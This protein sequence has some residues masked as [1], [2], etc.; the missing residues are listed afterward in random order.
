MEEIINPNEIMQEKVPN[1]NQQMGGSSSTGSQKTDDSFMPVNNNS[2][3]LNENSLEENNSK[4]VLTDA[5]GEFVQQAE[6][7]NTPQIEAQNTPQNTL[8]A[9][10]PQMS[11][12][13]V[14]S[15]NSF[16]LGNSNN[17]KQSPLDQKKTVSNSNLSTINRELEEKSTLKFAQELKL[18]Y[19]NIAKTPLN[20]DFL[21]VIDIEEAKK[22]RIIPFFKVGN[23]LRVALDDPKS[24]SALNAIENLK[25]KGFEVMINIASKSGISEAIDIYDQSQNYKKIDLIDTV[26]E[27]KIQTYEKEIED[28]TSLPERIKGLPAEQALNLINVSAMKTKASDIHYEPDKTAVRVRFRIDGVLNEVFRLD[29]DTYSNLSNQ[30]KYESKMRLNLFTVPQD[31]RY[32]FEFNKKSIGVRV[33]SIPTPYGE[34]FVCRFLIGGEKKY[35]FAE[36]GFQGLS[37]KKLEKS[38]NISQGMILSTGPTGSGKTTTLYSLISKMNSKESKIITLEDPVEYTI[39]GII[40]SQIDEKNG[41]TFAG[42]LRTILRQDPDI[43]MLGEI[44]DLDTAQVASQAALTGHVVLTTVHTNSAIETIPRLINMGLP[45]FM[46][47]PALNTIIAQR[48]VRKVCPNCVSEREITLS[49][50]KEFEFLMNSLRIIN[51]SVAIETPQKVPKINGCDKCSHTGYMGRLV[52]AEVITVNSEMKDLILNKASSIKMIM[53]ARKEGMI[54]LREDGFLKVAQGLTTL[55]EVYRVTNI[56]G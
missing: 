7:P 50:K 52:I 16:N 26:E 21:K 10:T 14:M 54:T 4:N 49:E 2:S 5:Q 43:I 12:T 41:Y 53:V 47:A 20:L 51:K 56:A 18:P 13:D 8:Q 46:V 38:S 39:E 42:G 30:I 44:R 29:N 15:Q 40:Q 48:L 1:T 28:L 19:V 17:E 11:T 34:S 3:N 32:S 25:K 35:E 6:V 55:E 27:E 36:L 31:G 23:K 24:K 22:S 33:S 37:L 45:A 9:E